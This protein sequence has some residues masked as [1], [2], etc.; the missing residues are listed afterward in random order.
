MTVVDFDSKR[1]DREVE[2]LFEEH[3][4]IYGE[5]CRNPVTGGTYVGILD[6]T[7]LQK[8]LARQPLMARERFKAMGPSDA[9][10]LP[11]SYD[12]REALKGSGLFPHIVAWY[13]RSLEGRAYNMDEHPPFADYVSGVLWEGELAQGGF[14]ALPNYPAEQL[15][16]LKE[17]SPARMLKGMSPGAHWLP[18]EQHARAIADLRRTSK[19]PRHHFMRV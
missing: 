1:V 8:E 13:A 6:P 14:V 3:P 10:P 16:E 5:L 4:P 12:E 15:R 11:I 18:A 17:R 9:Q 19:T 7:E 2:R